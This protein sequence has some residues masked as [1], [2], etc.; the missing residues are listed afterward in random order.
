M[1]RLHAH[2]IVPQ[3]ERRHSIFRTNRY[4]RTLSTPSSSTNS[5]R[6]SFALE[7]GASLFLVASRF[8]HACRGWNNVD[9]M[10]QGSKNQ[11]AFTTNQA[12]PAGTELT[13]RYGSPESL[14]Y[15]W[16]FDCTCGGCEQDK[17]LYGK[18]RYELPEVVW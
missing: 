18:A 3:A 2:Y 7:S 12:V 15:N 16:G 14:K 10:M 6:N 9:Y 17:K 4:V 1:L 11:I 5:E 13:I 8:N